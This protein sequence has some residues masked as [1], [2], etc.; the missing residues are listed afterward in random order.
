[1]IQNLSTE[2]EDVRLSCVKALKEIGKPAVPA[3]IKSFENQNKT[4][5]KYIV[6]SLLEIG[7]QRA[8]PYLEELYNESAEKTNTS[9]K[10]VEAGKERQIDQTLLEA[11]EKENMNFRRKWQ[12]LLKKRGRT[13][14]S[15]L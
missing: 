14:Q 13:K 9:A 2:N 8:V 15:H 3:L 7:D 10:L 6:F 4:V 1:M 11:M 5:R 12:E